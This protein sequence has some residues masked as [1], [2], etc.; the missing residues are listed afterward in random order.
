MTHQLQ[1]TIRKP[2]LPL[3]HRMLAVAMLAMMVS[4]A[5]AA[6][7]K[8]EAVV[9]GSN[10]TVGDVFDGAGTYAGY[11]LAPA[12]APGKT[13]VLRAADLSRVAT[14]FG[15]DWKPASG[16]EQIAVKSA[17]EAVDRAALLAALT[18]AAADAN[19][20]LQLPESLGQLFTP[21]GQSADITVE[22]ISIDDRRQTF[23][24]RIAVPTADGVSRIQQISGRAFAQV[25]VPVL[26]T[27]LKTGDII[28]DAD[29]DYIKRRKGSVPA[30]TLMTA[31]ALIG[32]TPR[33]MASAGQ[34]LQSNDLELPT[35]VKKGQ[36]VTVT[37]KSGVIALSLQGR[38]MQSGSTGDMVR[39]LNTASNQVIEATVTGAQTVA[40]TPPSATLL[41]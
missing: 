29:I 21:A 7:L 23:S 16:L 41:N 24:A 33:R 17:R 35:L 38:A 12:P 30:D 37:L 11:A 26:K 13:V 36:L 20:E 2:T 15:L 25:D 3:T 34:P 1:S 5:Q 31:D 27:A 8:S 40:V 10:L 18:T 28:S 22:S 4:H 9:A 19:I 6:T 14:T 39:I 32:H